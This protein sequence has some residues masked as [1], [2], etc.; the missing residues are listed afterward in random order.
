MHS[1]QGNYR[2]ETAIDAL[3]S[4][5]DLDVQLQINPTENAKELIANNSLTINN[6]VFQIKLKR[7]F[8]LNQ[9]P[10]L[11][12][13]KRQGLPFILIADAIS[14]NVKTVL[15]EHKINYLDASGNAFIQDYTGLSIFINGQKAVSKPEMNKDKAFT[16]KGLVVVYNLLIDDSLL[17]AT[18]RIISEKTETSLDTVTKVLQSLRQQG[19]IVQVNDK[20]M[21]LT[22]K[23]RLFEKWADAYEMRLKP[24][25]FIG[26]YRFKNIEA[27]KDW[28][29]ITLLP[30][31]FWGS[32]PA[33]SLLTDNYLRPE[34]FTLYS[35]ETKAELVNHYRFL[36]DAKGNIKVYLPFN[37]NKKQKTTSP[38][39][40]YADMLN[41]GIHRNIEVAEKIYDKYVKNSF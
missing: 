24:D 18:Y 34:I 15:R 17:N 2:I 33:A 35:T 41:S 26:N 6:I 7:D 14:D 1:L 25:L 3:K 16:K 12:D 19:F 39:W 32:E 40:V 27:E 31:S 23:K 28:Q 8:R 29:N 11:I 21:R 13:A 22:D 9:I 37:K 30:T 20:T 38:I 4:M 5:I 10:D 36:P